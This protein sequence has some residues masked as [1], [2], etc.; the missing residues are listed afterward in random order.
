MLFRSPERFL[1]VAQVLT[2]VASLAGRAISFER[3]VSAEIVREG[4]L[5]RN[6]FPPPVN[7]GRGHPRAPHLR[8]VATRQ[9]PSANISQRDANQLLKDL[10]AYWGKD[11]AS[12][13]AAGKPT[14]DKTLAD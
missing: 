14:V 12:R 4:V 1:G 2:D 9:Q 6:D 7:E 11:G 5:E 8:L 3:L 13:Q 10:F